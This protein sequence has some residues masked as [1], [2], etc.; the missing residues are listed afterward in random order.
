MCLSIENF[1]LGRIEP[2]HDSDEFIDKISLFEGKRLEMLFET[3]QFVLI[4]RVKIVKGF[5][6]DDLILVF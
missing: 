2:V 6:S 1:A 4:N 5:I 3:D